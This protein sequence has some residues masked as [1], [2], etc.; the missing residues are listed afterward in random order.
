M[1]MCSIQNASL[2]TSMPPIRLSNKYNV[3]PQFQFTA[4]SS[5]EKKKRKKIQRIAKS[6]EYLDNFWRSKIK[7]KHF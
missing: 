7:L 6:T 1:P 2:L 3:K 4:Q 5:G